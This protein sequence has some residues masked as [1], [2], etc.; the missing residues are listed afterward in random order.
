MKNYLIWDL[1]LSEA[2]LIYQSTFPKDNTLY[3][4]HLFCPPNTVHIEIPVSFAIPAE[5]QYLPHFLATETSPEVWELSI[6]NTTDFDDY[7]REVNLREK[8]VFKKEK[9]IKLNNKIEKQIES[10]QGKDI[11][12]IAFVIGA[13]RA[14]LIKD[15]P[16][17]HQYTINGSIETADNEITIISG[18]TNKLEIGSL[19]SGTDIPANTFVTGFSDTL[20]YVDKTLPANPG[21]EIV[22]TFDL[23]EKANSRLTDFKNVSR[24]IEKKR[25]QIEDQIEAFT[26]PWTDV[27]PLYPEEEE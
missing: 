1:I 10:A 21:V 25:K 27:T 16:S 7:K 13:I 9:Y 3:Y 4:S 6:R 5:N 20:I 19:V 15:N 14:K 24:K 12:D 17:Q 11:L 26:P 22:Y 18:N 2:V 8:L 23:E